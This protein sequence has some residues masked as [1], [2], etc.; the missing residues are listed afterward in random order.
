[1]KIHVFKDRRLA[2]A[3]GLVL[4]LAALWLEVVGTGFTDRLIERLDFLAYDLRYQ[5]ATPRLEVEH[6]IVIVDIDE[7]SLAA[8]GRWP[9]R[10]ERIGELVS[11]LG[12]AGALVV[13]FDVVF[14]EAERNPARLVSQRLPPGETAVRERLE[15][16]EAEVDGDRI[17]ARHLEQTETVLGFL[18]HHE[19]GRS[20]GV[21]PEPVL[22]LDPVRASALVVPRMGGYTGNLAPLQSAARGGGFMTTMPDSDGIIRRAPL[23][24][25]HGDRLYPSLALEMA[26]VLFFADGI[27][28]ATQQRGDHRSITAVEMGHLSLD[29]DAQGRALVPYQGGRFHYPYVSATDV[30]TDS[31]SKAERARL[32]D[33]LVLVGSSAQGLADLAATPVGTGFPGVEVHASLL[34][35]ILAQQLP[36]SPDWEQGLQL[37]TLLVV[38]VGLALVLPLLAPLSLLFTALLVLAGLLAGYVGLWVQFQLHVAVA[39]PV[40]L[41]AALLTV[42]LMF[43]LLRENRTRRELKSMFGQYVPPEHI[44]E[45]LRHPGAYGFAGETREMTVLFSDIRGFTSISERLDATELKALLNRFFTPVTRVIFEHEGT[46]D[47]Y[48]G[49]MVVAFWGAPLEDPRHRE[50]ALDAALAMLDEVARL[51]PAFREQGLPEISVGIGLNTGPMNVG[52]MGSGYRRAYTVLGDAVNLGARLESITKYYGARLLVGE[53][54]RDSVEGFVFRPV[55]RIQVKGKDEAVE[56][57]EPLGREGRVTDDELARLARHNQALAAYLQRDWDEAE[58]LW[59]QLAAEDP[60]C[61]LYTLYI[62]RVQWLR[63]EDPGPGWDGRFRHTSK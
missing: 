25:R 22:A 47:K 12:E 34:E 63:A 45:M 6:P 56:V 10:R 31:L 8:Q 57:F 50:H 39:L 17:L 58:R 28:L 35:G 62:E 24:L 19:S 32:Q 51:K 40:L 53:E 60:E 18:M 27:E 36:H 33:A 11:T 41:V 20:E 46:I 13:G 54:T 52:D 5:W 49:D 37:V 42:N 44:D 3:T 48:V 30:L 4:T 61:A 14:S 29:T 1:M 15:A 26:R 38:G 55:D 9:W 2:A 7:R 21:L 43:S 59:Q 23:I 16:I